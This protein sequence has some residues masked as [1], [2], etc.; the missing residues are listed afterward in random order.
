MNLELKNVAIINSADI[1]INGL[2]V[3]TGENSTGKTTV[4]K[5]LFSLLDSVENID[6]KSLNDKRNFASKE[7]K[8]ILSLRE[9]NY[10][11]NFYNL[12]KN[13]L[14]ID[15][16]ENIL[17]Y[18]DRP[19]PNH[20]TIEEML[21]YINHIQFLLHS[22][23]VDKTT[24]RIFDSKFF[25][26]PKSM[27]ANIFDNYQINIEQANAD[28][29]KVKE[30]L[31][32]DLE[33]KQ[34][35]ED[36]IVLTLAE[37]FSG[38]V[39]KIALDNNK[40]EEKLLTAELQL[41]D[42][43]NIITSVKVFDNTKYETSYHRF[44][45][46]VENVYFLD[47]IIDLD[48]ACQTNSDFKNNYGISHDDENL[49]IGYIDYINSRRPLTH[50]EKNRN[51]LAENKNISII[52][53]EFIEKNLKDVIAIINEILPGNFVKSQN[54]LFYTI[55]NAKLDVKNLASGSKAFGILKIL[56]KHGLIND[57]TIL[58]LD[59]PEVHLHP[60]RQNKF[61]EL[62]VMLVKQ[63]KVKILLTTHS[64]NFLLALETFQKKYEL[65]NTFSVYIAETIGTN[66]AKI[67]EI[68]DNIEEAY[69]HLARP[70]LEMDVLRDSF[71][72]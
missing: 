19:M 55:N 70:Y 69:A 64:P 25:K 34:Y 1:N 37:E 28:L 58:I 53:E 12:N 47:N 57:K 13:D 31:L 52:E 21:E 27:Y 6:K 16:E 46:S 61:A 48:Y 43:D 11:R 22:F 30:V 20:S 44:N 65:Q 51:L 63:L 59:E 42:N 8:K 72:N 4:G 38:Q 71:E 50:N 10:L 40:L 39:S 24:K 32:S 26:F 2:T 36:W 33:L 9:L 45:N 15:D 60:S 56:I 41:K 49:P 7:L 3:I 29:E 54:R 14:R 23:D 62:L 67:R 5:V 66:N 17:D 18:M 35:A 68:T